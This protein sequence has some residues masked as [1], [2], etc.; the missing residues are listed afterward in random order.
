MYNTIPDWSLEAFLDPLGSF[1]FILV[2]FG[3]NK[4]ENTWQKIEVKNLE[5]NA[6][7]PHLKPRSR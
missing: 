6:S 3:V 5:K 4:A 7:K 2:I 1:L